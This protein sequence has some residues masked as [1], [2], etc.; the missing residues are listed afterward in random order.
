MPCEIA[1]TYS[2]IRF[3]PARAA[4]IA[5]W[6]KCTQ[7]HKMDVNVLTNPLHAPERWIV[8]TAIT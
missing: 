5:R 6:S 4:L 7:R 3:L 8:K 2:G 1:F